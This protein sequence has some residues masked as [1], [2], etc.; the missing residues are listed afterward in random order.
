M[1]KIILLSLFLPMLLAP[2]MV[3]ATSTPSGLYAFASPSAGEQIAVGKNYDIKWTG[4]V[5]W[6]ATPGTTEAV[7]NVRLTLTCGDPSK[8]ATKDTVITQSTKN[9]GLFKWAVPKNLP[10]SNYCRITIASDNGKYFDVSPVFGIGSTP[11]PPTPTSVTVTVDPTFAS[12]ATINGGATNAVIGRFIFHANGEN[13]KVNSL[14]VLPVLTGTTS[15]PAGLNNVS[16]YFNGSQVGS[17]QNWTSGALTF[18][19]GSQMILPVGQDSTVEV[20]AD[21]MTTGGTAYT[22]GTLVLTLPAET[23]NAVGQTSQKTLGVPS[24]VVSTNGLTIKIVSL[25]VLPNPAFTNQNINPNTVNVK[26]GSYILQNPSTSNEPLRLTNLNVGLVVNGVAITNFSVLQV[27]FSDNTS[28]TNPIG[29]PTG[30]NNFPVNDTI[31]PGAQIILDISVNTGTATTG[32][33]QTTLQTT[34]IGAVDNVVN[35]S[36]VVPGQTMTL[37]APIILPSDVTFVPSASMTSQYVA[38]GSTIQIAT[39]NVKTDNNV[40]GAVLKDFTFTIASSNTVSAITVNGFT[41]MVVGTT[42]TIHNLGIPV[43]SVSSGVNIPVSVQLVCIRQACPGV[44]DTPVAIT[45]S[46]LTYTNGS[47]TASIYPSVSSST[48]TMVGSVPTVTIPFTTN[49]GLIIGGDANQIIGQTTVAA[50]T[51]GDIKVNTITFNVAGTGFTGN[52]VISNTV[53]TLNGGTTITGSSCNVSGTVIVCTLGSGYSTDFVVPVASSQ[54]FSLNAQVNGTVA[55]GATASISISL[56]PAGFIWDDVLG[57]GTSG[58]G[59][60]G[61]L[62]YGFPTGSYTIH[63]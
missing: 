33:I 15:A 40:G 50:G 36:P 53:I 30:T 43:P 63:Q 38:G 47:S 17:Q 22:A 5:R 10:V 39:L 20:R 25:G 49:S 32:T 11:V 12:Q 46:G 7:K 45:L 3:G 37:S 13:V 42:A 16:L 52:P 35:T 34:S 62:I 28:P 14:Q 19:L 24:V 8:G 27:R 26:I 54:V 6:I 4:P 59:L 18:Q 60:T 31:V 29:M 1:K 9:D 2:A 57:S 55:A 41:A 21:V 44:S 23:N 56:T 48:L 51:Q 58:V 61:S